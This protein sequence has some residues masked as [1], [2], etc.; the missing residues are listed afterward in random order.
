MSPR[1][2]F[3]SATVTS[4]DG[5]SLS[6]RST[7]R[8]PGLILLP[9]AFSTAADFDGLARAL[10]DAFSVHTLDRRGHGNSG[11]QGRDYCLDRECEDIAAVQAATGSTV[12]AGHSF[13]ALLALEAM[14]GGLDFGLAALYEPGVL[15][16]GGTSVVPKWLGRCRGEL[17]SER[18]L[19]SFITFIRGVNPQTTGRAP[20]ALL[21]LIL[22]LAIRR[23]ERLRKYS[24][25]DAAI[26][27][28]E[29]A[30]RVAGQPARYRSIVT[31]TLLMAGKEMESTAAG[32]AA[33]KLAS[34]LPSTRT[35]WFP[36][37]DHFGPEKAPET[38]AA[39]IKHF[40]TEQTSVAL[41]E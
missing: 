19:A 2:E 38:V 8:G 16:D 14:V 18:P 5:T 4:P 1:R 26:R 17:E 33:S 27:E 22:P 39:A 29:E 23:R 15:L 37:L 25:L 30:V 34:I 36:K 31:P 20:R 40:Y 41:A 7:G 9:G 24:L 6:Y 3:V 13:G 35:Q 28:H 11:P 10:S 32:R 12:V 21:R